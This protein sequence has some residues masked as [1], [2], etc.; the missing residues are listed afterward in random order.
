LH[1]DLYDSKNSGGQK[2]TSENNIDVTT[3]QAQ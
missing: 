3:L 1:I 2:H